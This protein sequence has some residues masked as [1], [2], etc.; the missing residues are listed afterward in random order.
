[1]ETSRTTNTSDGTT[2]HACNDAKRKEKK[3]KKKKREEEIIPRSVHRIE[4]NVDTKMVE[5][6]SQNM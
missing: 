6:R 3:K 2:T 1:M 5:P 4:T